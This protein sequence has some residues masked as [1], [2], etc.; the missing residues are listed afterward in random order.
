MIKRIIPLFIVTALAL[1]SGSALGQSA[2]S[3]V[4]TPGTS[5]WTIAAIGG[6]F[7]QGIGG[8][9]TADSYRALLKSSW[10]VAPWMDLYVLGGVANLKIETTDNTVTPL[11]DKFKLC[12]GLGMNVSMKMP[13]FDKIGLWGGVQAIRWRPE[14][15]FT[16]P[17]LIGSDLYLRRKSMKYDWRELKVFAG[18]AVPFGPVKFYAGGAGWWL[19]R[20]DSMTEYLE[21]GSSRTLVQSVENDT[22]SG[23][24][25]GGIA[26]IELSLPE[27]FA[28]SIEV[29]AFNTS[30]WKP[31]N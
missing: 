22:Q 28:L 8:T 12:Y 20:K 13:G 15:D 23:L 19:Q 25:T 31:L 3:P 10:G 4:M 21:N 24:W 5:E 9:E 14:G 16:E 29:M 6:Y 11:E 26:G 7:R 27:N 1:Q 17:D 2:A 30:N 18:V